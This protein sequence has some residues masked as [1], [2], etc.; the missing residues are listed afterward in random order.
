MRV[1]PYVPSATPAWMAVRAMVK[2]MSST[3]APLDRSL[4]G[5]FKPCNIGPMEMTSAERCTA[6]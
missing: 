3:N 1:F 5:F 6:L 4:T 2:T